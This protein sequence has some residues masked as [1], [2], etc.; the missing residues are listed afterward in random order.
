VA[1]DT[2]LTIEPGVKIIPQIGGATAL[3]IQGTLNAIA[4]SGAPII[5][6][7]IADADGSASTTPQKGDWLN[8]VFAAGSQGNLSYVEFRYGGGQDISLPFHEM[9]NVVGATVN[10][11]NSKF[12]N[13]KNTALHFMDSSGIVENSIFSDNN[14]GIS[15]DSSSGSATTV[16][17]GCYGLHTTG[18]ILSPLTASAREPK[19]QLVN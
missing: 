7:S 10:I 8:V 6:T 19:L 12:E 16:Y 9:V 4:T 11:N 13:S 15:V 14:C 5:F 18:L 17:G 2:I 1:S 3:E